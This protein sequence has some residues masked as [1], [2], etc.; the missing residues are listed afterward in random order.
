MFTAR[1]GVLRRVWEG[2]SEG[3]D[4]IAMEILLLNNDAF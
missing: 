2:S 1:G 3:D 4:L